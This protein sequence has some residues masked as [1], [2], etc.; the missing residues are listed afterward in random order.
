MSNKLIVL[1]LSMLVSLTSCGVSTNVQ[2]TSPATEKPISTATVA[3]T[4]TPTITPTAKPT[5]QPTEEPVYQF[6]LDDIP[7]YSGASYIT[8]NNNIPSFHDT[9][10]TTEVFERYSKHD[11]LGRCGVAYANVCKELM[12]TEERGN[13]GMVKPSG[14]H[15]I[16]YDFIDGM[17]LYNRCHLIAYQLAGEN[18]N[19]E[20]LITGTRY[21]NIEGMLPFENKT[22]D[23]V[24][25]TGN[26]VL[27]RVTPIFVGD[28]PL[29]LGVQM[30]A[31]SVEDNGAGLQ[32]NVFC[33][34]VQPGVGIDY[35][36][37]DSWSDGT[38]EVKSIPTKPPT[39]AAPAAPVS[40]G[41]KYILNTN[42]KKFHYPSCSSVS[43][44]KEKNKRE[45]TG[46]RDEA[47][48]QGFVPCKRCNP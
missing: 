40:S 8:L 25:S 21:L 43:D 46:T 1:L 23:Y 34:N 45:F 35:A 11:S 7:V 29:A 48:S 22:A 19:E 26:H 6:S 39:A 44:M 32:F 5:P 24:N 2:Q 9:E 15:T 3:V 13:I 20:N 30:E 31:K 4:S 18:A 28:N 47:I 36:T 12:P 42:T 33:Y 16:R 17:Y 38:M 37:G 41:T 10:M 27:Y 14:W